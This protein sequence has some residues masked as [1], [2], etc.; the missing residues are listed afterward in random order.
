ML[1]W[2]YVNKWQENEYRKNKIL[3][4]LFAKQ[5][6]TLNNK[7]EQPVVANNQEAPKEAAQKEAPKPAETKPK[8]K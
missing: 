8:N 3:E 1:G 4:A 2:S 7:A 6:E 5:T